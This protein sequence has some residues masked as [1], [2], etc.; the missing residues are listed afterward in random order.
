MLG[1]IVEAC[2]KSPRGDNMMLRVVLFDDDVF[3]LHG[4]KPVNDLTP[5]NYVNSVST[6][7]CT[8]AFDAVY[9]AILAS[10]QYAKDLVD[11]RYT[12]NAA[13]FL[14]TDGGDNRS[15]A[16]PKMVKEALE[17]GKKEEALESTMSVLIGIGFG[18]ESDI[19]Q[20]SNYLRDVH[21]K[22]GFQQYISAGDASPSTLAKIGGFVSKSASSQSQALG[23]GGPSISLT[24]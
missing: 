12:V 2:Q 19:S 11:Q 23:T 9:N 3:E 8:A 1:S 10:N 13:V 5:T 7:G 15:I 22:C 4:F 6:G 16:T 14:I 21:D 18:T 20:S 24:F 17:I